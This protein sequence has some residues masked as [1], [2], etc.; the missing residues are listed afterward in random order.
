MKININKQKILK[1][2]FLILGFFVFSYIFTFLKVYAQQDIDEGS[3]DIGGLKIFTFF[4]STILNLKTYGVYRLVGYILQLVL[5]YLLLL[6]LITVL[7][8]AMQFSRDKDSDIKDAFLTTQN[9]AQGVAFPFIFIVLYAATGFFLR[10][11]NIFDWPT[12]FAQCGEGDF[13]FRAEYKAAELSPEIYEGNESVLAFCCSNFSEYEFEQGADLK[14]AVKY[15]VVKGAAGG[16]ALPNVSVIKDGNSSKVEPV[17]V[18]GSQDKGGWVIVKNISTLGDDVDL[19]SL[20]T[21]SID[22]CEAYH[23][24]TR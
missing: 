17:V 12:Q 11:G 7:K 10:T 18:I 22:S 8:N 20:M 21:S 13:L 15:S 14:P 4:P 24:E 23:V 6:F 3:V 16:S 9:L 19:L 1:I 2:I 5:F